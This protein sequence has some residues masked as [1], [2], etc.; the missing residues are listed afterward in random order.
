MKVVRTRL[1]GV[2]L[3]EPRAFPD[4]RGFFMETWNRARY[5]EAGVDAAFVQDNLSF[6]RRH[7]LR[8][9]HFQ[10]P[11]A[12]G[13]LVCVLQGAVWDVAV[14]L[15]R[16]S[17]TFAEW[18]GFLL[19]AENR[20]QLYVPEGFAHG[21]VVTADTAL[22][23]YKCT[24]PYSAPHERSLR[25]NDPEVGVAWPVQAPVLSAK[26]A[27]APLLR[28]LPEAVLFGAAEAEAVRG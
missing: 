11:V 6:S 23:S 25:W 9:L 26:D 4:E 8:G 7:V 13:K 21:F 18:E 24:A 10:N 28:E 22:F 20:R 5:A 27:A 17:P 3:I 14:D 15:R 19:S 12:Q 2:V 16:G 1:E